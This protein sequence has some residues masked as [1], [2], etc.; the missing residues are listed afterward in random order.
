[1][2]A[3]FESLST[4]ALYPVLV[5]VTPNS[6]GG[7]S[8]KYIDAIVP[9][10]ANN[11]FVPPL[12]VAVFLLLILTFVKLV[13]SYGNILLAWIISNKVVQETQVKM[14]Q[15]LLSADYH[16]LVNVQKGDLAY[17]VLTAP[18]YTGKVINLVPMIVV[19]ALKVLTILLVLALI[20][21]WVTFYFLLLSLG[22]F[23]LTRV[24]AQKVSYGTGSGRAQSASNQSIHT[25]NA[26]KGIKTIRL[27]GVINHW[28]GLFT[29]EC[30]NFY[31]YARKDAIFAGVP[32]SLLEL[33]SVLFVSI[34]VLFFADSESGILSSIP[35]LGVFAYSLLKVMPSL[36]Q[37]S[38]YWMGLMSMLPHLEAA[39]LAVS[40]MDSS[41]KK[42]VDGRERLRGVNSCLEIRGLTFFYP[43]A[44]RPALRDVNITISKGQFVGV[45]GPSGSGKTTLLDLLAGLLIPSD[46]EILID[47][48]PLS[49]YSCASVIDHM[50]YVGQDTFLFNDTVRNNILF[51]RDGFNEGQIMEALK[52]SEAL[53]FVESMPHGL[54]EIIADDGMKMSGG[55]RQRLSIAR[56][57]LR[58]PE[59]LLLDEA[60]SALDY[61]TEA[62]I[63][64]T[65]LRLVRKERKTVIFVTHRKSAIQHADM[66]IEIRDGQ[67]AESG[68]SFR[69]MK[70]N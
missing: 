55:Q 65:I 29:K 69:Q 60:T 3:I 34:L 9:W 42:F 6:T 15:S 37:I 8:N 25:L 53:E 68:L 14:F 23:L 18:G 31:L 44:A 43:G 50:G 45:V 70:V 66:A 26:L 47:G 24:V 11:I 63:V 46:G 35:V 30:R 48:K 16:L 17:R 49:I 67:I 10:L 38:T 61:K 13:L 51:G 40:E 64:E 62:N 22:Y 36:K 39:Y 20:S 4:V 59:I 12:H 27:Y 21:P 1:M 41:S 57:M 2:G 33:S 56:A 7:S 32:T 19:E 54:D 28:A 52:K 58:S 5:L